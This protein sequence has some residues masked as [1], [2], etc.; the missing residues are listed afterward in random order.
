VNPTIFGSPGLGKNVTAATNTRA[1]TKTFVE[2][3][4]LYAVLV[5]SKE[6][7]S[8]LPPELIFSVCGFG[9]RD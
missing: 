4:V 7:R 1:T 6:N 5:V 9:F 8:V 3:V 2:D